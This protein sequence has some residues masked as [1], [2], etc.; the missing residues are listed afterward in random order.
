MQ[1]QGRLSEQHPKVI[2]ANSCMEMKRRPV[3]W[4]EQFRS[5]VNV[6]WWRGDSMKTK[7]QRHPK[8]GFM[9]SVPLKSVFLLNITLLGDL[10]DGNQPFFSDV[11]GDIDTKR[12]V[13]LFSWCFLAWIDNSCV[14]HQNEF[15]DHAKLGR[16]GPQ[17]K[18]NGYL[19]TH[20]GTLIKLRLK[21]VEPKKLPDFAWPAT[22]KKQPL[23]KVTKV[24]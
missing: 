17:R 7:D 8:T 6:F 16:L 19:V 23:G 24:S 13:A 4:N 21:H 3:S 22:H 15:Y 14:A 1:P 9:K 12:V 18:L 2:W 10:N 20:A 5:K 11:S